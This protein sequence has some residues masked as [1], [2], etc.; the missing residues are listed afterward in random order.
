MNG[1]ENRKM[2]KK[3]EYVLES[4]HENQYENEERIPQRFEERKIS[5]V[6]VI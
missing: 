2:K 5:N 6:G 3:P 1:A 4:M